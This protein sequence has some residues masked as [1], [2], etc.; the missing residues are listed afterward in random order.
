MVERRW[1]APER[2]HRP[3]FGDSDRV[4]RNNPQWMCLSNTN[5]SHS[6]QF[7]SLS[8]FQSMPYRHCKYA[9]S[10]KDPF[11]C[12]SRRPLC[13][14]GCVDVCVCV[15]LIDGEVGDGGCIQRKDSC[16]GDIS[17]IDRM[18]FSAGTASVNLPAS[19]CNSLLLLLIWPFVERS[20]G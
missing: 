8:L 10:C 13:T 18:L 7:V 1:R 15:A 4:L 12:E 5:C 11:Y 9:L 14:A 3:R 16:Q 2:W 19:L 6:R 17:W 20:P